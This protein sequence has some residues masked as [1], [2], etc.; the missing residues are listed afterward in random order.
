MVITGPIVYARMHGVGVK[1]S[2]SYDKE[3]LQEVAGRAA[4][5]LDR[6][7]DTFVYFNNDAQAHA[8]QNAWELGRLVEN[9]LGG[10]DAQRSYA[11]QEAG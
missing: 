8:V 9:L 2:G 1:Y 3:Q 5:H 11:L 7:Y 10:D 4:D 6:G